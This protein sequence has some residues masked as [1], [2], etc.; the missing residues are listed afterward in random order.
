MTDAF[1]PTL[2]LCLC[3]ST[4]SPSVFIFDDLSLNKTALAAR[5]VLNIH[6]PANFVSYVLVF[7]PVFAIM[8]PTRDKKRPAQDKPTDDVPGEDEL[9]EDDEGAPPA[10][11]T[12]RAG[13][14]IFMDTHYKRK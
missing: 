9:A 5:L 13:W 2:K 3:S 10:K 12:G 8:A 6:L 11:K 14:L 4:M 7:H 1:R